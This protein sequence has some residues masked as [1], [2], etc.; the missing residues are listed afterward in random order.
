LNA[1]NALLAALVIVTIGLASL[2]LD[3]SYQISRLDSQLNSAKSVSLQTLTST[4]TSTSPMTGA[5]PVS[6]IYPWPNAPYNTSNSLANITCGVFTYGPIGTLEVLSVEA[7]GFNGG[8]LV[9]YVTVEN[10]SN[11][12]ISFPSY[13]LNSNVIPNPSLL[14][15]GCNCPGT[16]AAQ[17]DLDHAQNFTLFSPA[18]GDQFVYRLAQPG[19]VAVNLNFSWTEV[20][21][22]P[23]VQ[24]PCSGQLPPTNTTEIL[25]QFAFP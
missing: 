21:P 16:V 2:T 25:A 19:S 18:S 10:I 15:G 5:C 7:T 6:R 20:F 9:F 11:S 24:A 3:Q 13:A 4:V 1:K 17:I 23:C 14:R 8:S 12:T 22:A